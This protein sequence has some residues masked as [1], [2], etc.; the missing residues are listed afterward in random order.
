MSAPARKSRGIVRSTGD[1]GVSI[2]HKHRVAEAAALERARAEVASAGAGTGSGQA[3][4]S[5]EFPD[6]ERHPG[7]R[8]LN[9]A[10]G[11]L[12]AALAAPSKKMSVI[13]LRRSALAVA[14]ELDAEAEANTTRTSRSDLPHT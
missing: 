12:A 10:V 3:P 2:Y 8:S 4:P 1:E 7:T 5:S 13:A 9:A 6:E 14:D 11:S